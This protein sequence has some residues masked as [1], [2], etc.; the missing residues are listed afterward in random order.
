MQLCPGIFFLCKAPK[1]IEEEGSPIWLKFFLRD[2]QLF[3]GVWLEPPSPGVL[4]ENPLHNIIFSPNSHT[5]HLPTVAD[6]C[7]P[8]P[9]LNG[10]SCQPEGKAY[11]CSCAAG[12]SGFNCSFG[13]LVEHFFFLCSFSSTPQPKHMLVWLVYLRRVPSACNLQKNEFFSLNLSRW[14]M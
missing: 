7:T 2:F 13:L 6:L 1:K 14:S 3:E 4:K 12:W 10:G 9:C 11:Q 5:F 8:N